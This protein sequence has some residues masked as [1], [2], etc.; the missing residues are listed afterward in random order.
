MRGDSFSKL[1]QIIDLMNSR[2]A[3]D[4]PEPFEK[5]SD[6]HKFY[7]KFIKQYNEAH[8]NLKSAPYFT[9]TEDS[10][11]HAIYAD[12]Q[13]SKHQPKLRLRSYLLFIYRY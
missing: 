12:F 11:F 5:E 3:F 7:T 10:S 6:D 9:K 8:R 2:L 1:H 4:R 13:K